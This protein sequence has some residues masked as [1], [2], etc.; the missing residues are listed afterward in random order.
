M[1]DTTWFTVARAAAANTPHL[2]LLSLVARAVLDSSGLKLRLDVLWDASTY[3]GSIY[4]AY[5]LGCAG[6]LT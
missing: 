3:T 4:T 2:I 6:A 5:I 1:L